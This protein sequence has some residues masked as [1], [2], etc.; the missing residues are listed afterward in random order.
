[1][2]SRPARFHPRA[3]LFRRAAGRRRHHCRH[4]CCWSEVLLPRRP[5][6]RHGHPHLFLVRH[7]ATPREN[8]RARQA[9]DRGYAECKKT[10][11]HRGRATTTMTGR[12]RTYN[13]LHLVENLL[14]LPLLARRAADVDSKSRA[15]RLRA[16]TL[17]E[18]TQSGPRRLVT[19]LAA[20]VDLWRDQ[21]RDANGHRA[22]PRASCFASSTLAAPA[23]PCAFA[24]R[25]SRSSS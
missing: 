7:T 12:R 11:R 18:P 22:E 14:N 13:L 8:D 2:R 21:P 25:R 4:C 10:T 24:A 17:V 15:D 16:L 23:F 6:A 3:A 5:S 20:A 9:Q 1:M 19:L